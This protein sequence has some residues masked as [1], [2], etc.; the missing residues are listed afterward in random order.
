MTTK[1]LCG[2]TTPETA[3]L[4]ADYPYGFKLRCQIRY[5]IE[6]TPKRGFRF[7]SQTSNPKRGGV[8]NK[9][10]AST[11]ARFGGAMYLDDNGHVQWTG[12]TEYC[13]AAEA[14]AFLEKFGEA[15]PAAGLDLLKKW[16]T[17]KVAYEARKEVT[18]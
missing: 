5:W 11:Y 4:V 15:V 7:V 16:V 1:L 9:P 10:K 3:Y 6:F 18:Q 17:A 2:H 12:L 13:N 14:T 8:W